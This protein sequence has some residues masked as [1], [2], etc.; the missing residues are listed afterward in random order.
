MCLIPGKWAYLLHGQGLT[1]RD[2]P[3]MTVNAR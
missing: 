2:L 3:I 1:V